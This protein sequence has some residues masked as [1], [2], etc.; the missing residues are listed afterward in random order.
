MICRCATL[1]LLAALLIPVA[2][3]NTADSERM[4]GV[5]YQP[6]PADWPI[7]VY[8]HPFAP[9]LLKD[10]VGQR[11]VTQGPSGAEVIG[12]FECAQVDYTS[13]RAA[14]L[15]RAIAAAQAE[16]RSIGGDAI[17]IRSGQAGLDGSTIQGDVLRY[18]K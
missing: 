6:R 12:A 13:N 18:P 17:L 1:G 10:A 11:K 8:I 16:A 9:P 7:D 15:R 14:P 4:P 2:A 5:E 3:C